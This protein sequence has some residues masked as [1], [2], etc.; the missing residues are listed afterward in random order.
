[1]PPLSEEEIQRNM[2]DVAHAIAQELEGLKVP[3]ETI[4]DL[5]SFARGEI[6]TDEARR[7]VYERLEK[8]TGADLIAAL[9]SSPYR[10]TDIE[11][12]R[13]RLPCPFH[14][15]FFAA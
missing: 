1:M 5:Q 8:R 6:D 14:K 15:G 12:E 7:R 11:P 13:Y 4:A 3:Q 10:D 9:Q 2:Q